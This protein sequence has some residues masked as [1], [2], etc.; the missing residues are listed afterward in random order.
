MTLFTTQKLEVP[1]RVRRVRGRRVLFGTLISS[2]IAMIVGVPD[3][4]RHRV[5]HLA[6]RVAAVATSLGAVVDLLAAVP[7]LVFGMWGLYFLVPNTQ[8]SRSG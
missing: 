1:A 7:S 8:A 2:I 3:R 6:V 4:H 5:V